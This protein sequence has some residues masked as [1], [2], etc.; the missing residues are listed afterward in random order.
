MLST[1]K[2]I[3]NKLCIDVETSNHS[4]AFDLKDNIDTF[5]KHDI[6]PYLENYFSMIEEDLHSHIIQIPYLSVNVETSSTLNYNELKEDVKR[7]LTKE[8]KRV[9]KI[10]HPNSVEAKLITKE[11]NKETTFL[12]FL[13]TGTSPWWIKSE[14]TFELTEKDFE[15][16]L[17]SKGFLGKLRSKLMNT[18]FRNRMIH[19]LSDNQLVKVIESIDLERTQ[20]LWNKKFFKSV[21]QI[22]STDR[23]VFWDCLVDDVHQK[24]DEVLVSRLIF[25]FIQKLSI[26]ENQAQITK[27]TTKQHKAFFQLIIELLK[28]FQKLEKVQ[29]AIEIVKNS[30][31]FED[32]NFEFESESLRTSDAKSIIVIEGIENKNE[33]HVSKEVRS[34]KSEKQSK[35]SVDGHNTRTK[36][37]EIKNSDEDEKLLKKT[38]KQTQ[39]KPEKSEVENER[40]P[41]SHKQENESEI[42]PKEL[43]NI[44][45]TVDIDSVIA[46]NEKE[47]ENTEKEQITLSQVKGSLS[48]L[49]EKEEQTLF[50]ELNKLQNAN[51]T[52]S[53]IEGEIHINN[54]G[55]ILLHPYLKDFFK[56]CDVLDEKNQ[57]TDKPLAVHLLHYLATKQEQQY[58]SNM[59]FEKVLCGI[60]VQ[61]PI[62]R[63]IRLSEEI[64]ANAEE[65]L[66]AVLNNWGVLNNASP[67]LLR[68]EFL[69]RFGKISFKEVNPKITVE[70]KV[71]DI[72]LDKLPWNIGISRLPWLD[73][74]LFTDW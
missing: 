31:Q 18:T 46:S 39:S 41:Y 38:D 21:D 52:N 44:T 73:Y 24:S 15:D 43:V 9:T 67:D 25:Q 68:G 66:Q 40:H 29:D 30:S 35:Q 5:L 34:N 11:E 51:K 60:P 71:H 55:L 50:Q 14:D 49:I 56:H 70:R 27:T 45:D 4:S 53:H 13:E 28:N 48:E 36:E 23:K 74:L 33:I 19:Q 3:I 63:T 10:A 54:A 26:D 65:L 61:E 2:H 7:V 42:E 8:I 12:H 69:Q 6:L 62:Q 20:K 64:K 1:Q 59:V 58:E 17:A 72:L 57:I 32:L 37:S 22:S 16:F 47:S